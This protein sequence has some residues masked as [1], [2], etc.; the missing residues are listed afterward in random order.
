M[1][2]RTASL[3]L[4]AMLCWY[5]VN[6]T[7]GS[8][9][10]ARLAQGTGKPA[11]KNCELLMPPAGAGEE[12]GH[13]YLVQVWPRAKDID[14]H[15]SGCQ[16]V[17]WT[18]ASQPPRLAW[19]VEVVNGDPLR[20]W[21]ADPALRDISQCVYARGVLMKG[22]PDLCPVPPELLMPSQAAGCVTAPN[23]AAHCDY[24]VEY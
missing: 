17:F 4:I 10:E 21:S 12:S 15:Y 20:R 7:A 18:T 6:A 14:A 11:G 9:E 1:R 5:A 8:T 2:L 23:P 19:L 3:F 16:A 24:D 22:S 13:G